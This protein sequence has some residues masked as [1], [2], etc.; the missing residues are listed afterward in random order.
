MC[1][2]GG[3]GGGLGGR[4]YRLNYIAARKDRRERTVVLDDSHPVV[5]LENVH[6]VALLRD[7]QIIDDHDA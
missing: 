6:D 1:G 7:C 5:L 4:F 3:G 2:S